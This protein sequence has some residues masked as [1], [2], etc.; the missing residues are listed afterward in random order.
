MFI[1]LFAI[2]SVFL[3]TQKNSPFLGGQYAGMSG[4]IFPRGVNIAGMSDKNL[5]L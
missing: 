2:V 4:N 5:L 1:V 3:K